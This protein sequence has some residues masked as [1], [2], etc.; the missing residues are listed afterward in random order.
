V[1]PVI[2]NDGIFG[3]PDFRRIGDVWPV[4][5]VLYTQHVKPTIK[6]RLDEGLIEAI[7][8]F[9]SV[10]PAKLATLTNTGNI[11]VVVYQVTGVYTT[12]SGTTWEVWLKHGTRVYPIVIARGAVTEHGVQPLVVPI[13]LGPGDSISIGAALGAPP[14]FDASW[15]LKVVV[16]IRTDAADSRSVEGMRN[17]SAPLVSAQL[18]VVERQGSSAP[19]LLPQVINFGFV[20]RSVTGIYSE[21]TPRF[22]LLGNS[23]SRPLLVLGFSVDDFG[24]GF[25]PEPEPEP[26]R[27]N[28]TDL[29]FLPLDPAHF[30]IL[31]GEFARIA[32][33]FKPLLIGPIE[34]QVRF[35]TDGGP[36]VAR[37]LA[38]VF[39]ADPV[40]RCEPS[41]VQ[42]GII[43]QGQVAQRA[44][45]I[46]NDGTA[47][48]QVDPPELV[49]PGFGPGSLTTDQAL[50]LSIEPGQS[51]A[52]SLHF[53]PRTGVPTL[54]EAT[55]SIRCNDPVRP[56]LDLQITGAVAATDLRAD[57]TDIVFPATPV[58]ANQPQLPPN[59]PPTVHR[60]PTRSFHIYNTG[61]ADATI[62]SLSI[63]GIRNSSVSPHF[64][65]WADDG[66]PIAPTTRLLRAGEGLLLIVE[67]S[68]ASPGHHEAKIEVWTMPFSLEPK[69]TI[70]IHG[71]AF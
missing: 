44:V 47:T 24:A 39:V 43:E 54:L 13:Q 27:N 3:P 56:Q 30:Q 42:F 58:A 60:G 9:V 57:P 71:V 55:C 65:L 49:A 63:L 38:T 18:N 46:F 61:V 68:A 7:A 41:Q 29:E 51:A 69:L 53:S 12:G 40:I 16:D 59:L 2:T 1:R 15:Q 67:F 36:V 37:L 66:S 52:I 23:G 6:L 45:K 50:P 20:T 28:D 8:G 17:E 62:Q 31:P 32:V 14:E 70:G 22:L 35:D 4:L 33:K 19:Y 34:T 21:P 5:G 48:L 25:Q 10:R 11:A 64:K 26:S